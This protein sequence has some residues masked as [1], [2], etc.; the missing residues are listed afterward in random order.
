MKYKTIE[1]PD[2]LKELTYKF[3]K[4][5]INNFNKE[6]KLNS[7]DTISLY[8]LSNSFNQYLE[9]EEH[10]KKEGLVT[11]SDR[12][13]SSLSPYAIQQKVVQSQIAV[14]LKEL[15]LTLGSRSKL[16]ILD[17]AEEESPLMKFIATNK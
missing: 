11:I 1:L 8:L 14:L 7:L 15:G 12:G 13:N 2:G 10:L 4:D 9:C 16:K 3:I 5:I 17:T 6:N